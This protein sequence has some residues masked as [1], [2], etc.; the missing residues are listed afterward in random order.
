MNT[1]VLLKKLCTSTGLSKKEKNRNCI[2]S[3]FTEISSCLF[4]VKNSL[5][6]LIFEC[7]FL[8]SLCI[9]YKVYTLL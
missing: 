3:Y 8:N 7:L 9:N 2:K 4:V 5:T 6:S 1:S